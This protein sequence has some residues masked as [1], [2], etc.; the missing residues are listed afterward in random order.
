M[1]QSLRKFFIILTNTEQ[2]EADLLADQRGASGRL[3]VTVSTRLNARVPYQVLSSLQEPAR[4]K[5]RDIA[6]TL[7]E[8]K[9]STATPPSG[10]HSSTSEYSSFK[11][12]IYS[13]RLPKL[14]PPHKQQQRVTTPLK[15]TK[16]T[17]KNDNGM[18]QFNQ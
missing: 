3:L 4:P 14:I 9:R 18:S 2:A 5:A 11:N 8:L 17:V 10:Q 6:G 12:N 13:H 7:H 16:D 1:L 15:G